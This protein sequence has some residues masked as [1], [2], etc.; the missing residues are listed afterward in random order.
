MAGLLHA[1]AVIAQHNV[2]EEDVERESR[3]ALV[4]CISDAFWLKTHELL[5][6]M[7]NDDSSLSACASRESL[8]PFKSACKMHIIVAVL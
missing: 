6:H 8:L 4:T 5:L 2:P 1:T 7:C 3:D